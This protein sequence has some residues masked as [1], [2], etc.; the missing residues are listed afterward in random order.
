MT[1][2]MCLLFIFFIHIS[3]HLLTPHPCF[4]PFPSLS[5]W[6]SANLFFVSMSLFCIYTHVYDSLDPTHKCYHR[7]L[8]FLWL[9]HFIQLILSNSLHVAA[10]GK[11][12]FFLMAEQYSLHFNFQD[13]VKDV[14]DPRAPHP[15]RLWKEL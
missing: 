5:L 8:V 13:L 1:D 3:L 11:V 10:D 4:V 7:A 12:S 15:P 9:T 6:I 2:N 14:I